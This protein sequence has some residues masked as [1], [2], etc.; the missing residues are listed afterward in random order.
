MKSIVLHARKYFPKFLLVAL[1]RG[2]WFVRVDH[3]GKGL[4]S[5]EINV[6]NTSCVFLYVLMAAWICSRVLPFVSGTTVTT[7]TIA[8]ALIAA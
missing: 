5:R 4:Y 6:F 1:K 3:L 8:S 2:K 7:N